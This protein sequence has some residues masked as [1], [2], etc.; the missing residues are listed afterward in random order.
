MIINDA[1]QLVWFKPMSGKIAADFRTQTY[2]GKPVLTWWEGRLFVGD[3]TGEGVIYDSTYSPVARVR[4]ANGFPFDL[5]EFTITPRGTALI[6]VYQRD[7]Q[8]FV[9]WGG[10]RDGRVVDS[11]VQEID[12]KTGLVLFEWHS[13]GNVG[14]SESGVP[15]PKNRG[16]EW[17]YLH[18]NA[19]A[20]TADGNL[21]VSGRNTSGIYKIS[22]ATGKVLWRLGGTKSDFK[23]GP[24]VRFDWQHSVRELP[25]GTLVLYDNS[26]APPK[27]K[28]SR[29]LQIRLDL[30]ARTATLVH[31]FAHPRNLLSASQGNVEQLSNGN[32]FVGFGSQRWFS[33]FSPSGELLFDGRLAKGNDTYRA[34]RFPWSGRPANTPRTAA[35]A[36]AG[37]VSARA[38]WN[39]ATGVARWQL[40][41]G[42]TAAT[43]APIADG[44]ATGFETAVTGATTQPLVAMRALDAA[45]ATLSTSPPV[46]PVAVG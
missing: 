45:G 25:D 10:K 13:L 30:N 33:E 31:A 39:G 41:A 38:S 22:R 44:P 11:I 32:T 6:T 8:S 40:L 3:G 1:G 28:Q 42:A 43:L 5:H 14:L 23:L 19:I 46:M 27:R 12:I 15:A 36:R 2:D 17:D 9:A 21:L 7:K 20:E 4:A 16:G 18:I 29:A 26:A 35:R 34:F 24:G 37:Q